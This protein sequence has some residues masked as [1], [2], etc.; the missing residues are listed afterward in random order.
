MFDL[1]I[2]MMRFGVASFDI[3]GISEKCSRCFHMKSPFDVKIAVILLKIT[4]VAIKTLRTLQPRHVYCSQV[5]T[6]LT[7]EILLAKQSE[8]F[9]RTFYGRFF[10]LGLAQLGWCLFFFHSWYFFCIIKSNKQ[11]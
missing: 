7:R 5:P 9:Q 1:K 4:R 8:F 3:T 2:F 10:V 11:I 6:V